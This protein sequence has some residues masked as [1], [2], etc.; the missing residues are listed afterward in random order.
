M[1]SSASKLG[2][3]KFPGVLLFWNTLFTI[4]EAGKR[5][6]LCMTCLNNSAAVGAMLEHPL[7]S[8]PY[9]DDILMIDD[10]IYPHFDTCRWYFDGHWRLYFSAATSA[11]LVRTID[12]NF[13]CHSN[14]LSWYFFSYSEFWTKGK[15]GKTCLWP[16]RLIP[17]CLGEPKLIWEFGGLAMLSSSRKDSRN[18]SEYLCLFLCVYLFMPM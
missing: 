4:S 15:M 18:N 9:V 3:A 11:I 2:L 7:K 16:F 14:F 17:C 12:E 1:G 13:I 6:R 5:A 10:V 8:N